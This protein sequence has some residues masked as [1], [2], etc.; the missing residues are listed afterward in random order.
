MSTP[1]W[2]PSASLFC[3]S[4]SITESHLSDAVVSGWLELYE[5]KK[6]PL[7]Y[8]TAPAEADH[9]ELAPSHQL[10]GEGPEM[11]IRPPR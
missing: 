7:G 6:S 10:V 1:V 9:G 5:G 11:P 4:V 2:T 3:I 8:Q